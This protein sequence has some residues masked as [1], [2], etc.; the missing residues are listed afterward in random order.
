MHKLLKT[1]H[2]LGL[3]TG[4]GGVIAVIVNGVPLGAT[5]PVIISGL[6][7]AAVTGAAMM[8]RAGLSPI[9][10]RWLLAHIVTAASAA[11]LAALAATPAGKGLSSGALH[12]IATLSACLLVLAIAIGVFKPRIGQ[13]LRKRSPS[14]AI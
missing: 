9:R 5:G 8:V 4:F 10:Q 3:G 11:V 6:A 2:L 14:E 13:Q 7:G 1:V 12:I